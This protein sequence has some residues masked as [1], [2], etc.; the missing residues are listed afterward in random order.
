[1]RV[2]GLFHIA[3]GRAGE[4]LEC[5]V[6]I[7]YQGASGVDG[8]AGAGCR[9]G[10]WGLDEADDCGCGIRGGRVRFIVTDERPLGPR[11]PYKPNRTVVIPQHRLVPAPLRFRRRLLGFRPTL[12]PDGDA[13]AGVG[14]EER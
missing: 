9:R 10:G 4:R 11:N 6:Q 14:D 8:S 12:A 1:M 5:G 7:V 13:L 2:E 3:R